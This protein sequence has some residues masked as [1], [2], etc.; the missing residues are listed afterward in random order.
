MAATSVT[1]GPG[2][3]SS[4]GIGCE[5]AVCE[6]NGDTGATPPLTSNVVARSLNNIRSIQ[7]LVRPA[8][9]SS[10]ARL[11]ARDIKSSKALRAPGEDGTALRTTRGQV[12]SALS[13]G[14][15]RRVQWRFAA[16]LGAAAPRVPR[17][18][19]PQEWEAVPQKHRWPRR[20][21]FRPTGSQRRL[22][23]AAPP[24]HVYYGASAGRSGRNKTR[25][26]GIGYEI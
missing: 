2:P 12:F 11:P 18:L 8:P 20:Q 13:S 24:N 17:R 22:L 7:T 26:N 14:G 25:P 1:G 9:F 3:A 15:I 19:A 5:A 23:L 21:C 16:R 4:S 10:A 6:F